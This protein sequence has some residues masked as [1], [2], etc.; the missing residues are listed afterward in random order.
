MLFRGLED[1]F[2][3]SSFYIDFTIPSP[4]TPPS[5]KPKPTPPPKKELGDITTSKSES[6]GTTFD[7][8]SEYTKMFG[9]SW[10]NSKGTK[11]LSQT[12]VKE[13]REAGFDVLYAPTGNKHHIRIILGSKQFDDEGRGVL[14]KLFKEIGRKKI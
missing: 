1:L 12:T 2:L 8:D 11:V 3:L 10:K 9:E 6:I 13:L 4:T 14:D 7:V 5:P